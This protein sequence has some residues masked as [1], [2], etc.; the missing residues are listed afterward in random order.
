MSLKER[1][2]AESTDSPNTDDGWDLTKELKI[3]CT[4]W[5]ST[6][7]LVG[8]VFIAFSDVIAGLA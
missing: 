7:L 6:A 3:I 1:Q 5:L 2:T 8:F 4:L